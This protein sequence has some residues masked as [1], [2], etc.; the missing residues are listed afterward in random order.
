[1]RKTCGEHRGEIEYDGSVYVQCPLCRVKAVAAEIL[2]ERAENDDIA[3]CCWG[4]LID[5]AGDV[6]TQMN[7]VS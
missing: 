5:V 2:E 3:E 6:E 1:M 4:E 7:K